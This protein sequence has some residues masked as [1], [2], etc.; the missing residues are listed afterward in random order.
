MYKWFRKVILAKD[1]PA[2]TAYSPLTVTEKAKIR[3]VFQPNISN[4]KATVEKAQV[5]KYA[6]APG[7]TASY[8]DVIGLAESNRRCA[9]TN[10]PVEFVTGPAC[11]SF[12]RK[13]GFTGDRNKSVGKV[14]YLHT[15]DN[16]EVSCRA[17]N[18]GMYSARPS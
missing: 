14:K 13:I 18:L 5:N 10:V 11:I 12:N 17:L 3:A 9:T 4:D 8:E 7:S 6:V 16:I 2:P 15:L 1:A